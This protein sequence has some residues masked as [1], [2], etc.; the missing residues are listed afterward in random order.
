MDGSAHTLNRIVVTALSE[1]HARLL[2]HIAGV[3]H[4]RQI[5]QVQTR[6]EPRAVAQTTID[7]IEHTETAAGRKLDEYTRNRIVAHRQSSWWE[8]HLSSLAVREPRADEWLQMRPLARNQI[9][10][11]AQQIESSYVQFVLRVQAWTLPPL[12]ESDW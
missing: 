2:R 3:W 8:W 4:Q 7:L 5:A 10:L 9:L 11:R 1:R 12:D 6:V